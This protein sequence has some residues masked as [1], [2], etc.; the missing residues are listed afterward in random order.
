MPRKKAITEE[1]PKPANDVPHPEF[2][3]SDKCVFTEWLDK[4]GNRLE[5]GQKALARVL[6]DRV[7]PID[8]EDPVDPCLI[9]G[10]NT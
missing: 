1:L 5:P 4:R 9:R 6:F 8:I 10:Q 2:D 7:D 3:D